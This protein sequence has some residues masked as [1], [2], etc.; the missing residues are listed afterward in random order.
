MKTFFFSPRT[1]PQIDRM[2]RQ[3][4]FAAAFSVL[5]LLT[6]MILV[7][8]FGALSFLRHH[9]VI[10]TLLGREWD[11]GRGQLQIGLFVVESAVVAGL[12]M[13]VAV[14]FGLGVAIFGTQVAVGF[15]RHGLRW[16]LTIASAVPSVAYG[17]WGLAVVVPGLRGLG[18]GSGYSLLAA[19]LV[20]ALMILPTFSVLAMEA[21]SQV[22]EDWHQASLALGA[23][24][25]Q[26]LVRLVLPASLPGLRL[27]FLTAL[28]RAVGETMAVQMVIGGTAARFHGL[29]GPG[30]T[31]TT[32]ILT[33][34]A[35]LPNGSSDHGVLDLMAMVLFVGVTAMTG[36]VGYGQGR[37]EK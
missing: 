18:G 13:L 2:W 10:S 21:L 6:L 33:D 14:P 12:A 22:P 31:L 15:E 7:L 30:A 34:M 23:N 3:I 5:A 17:W 20:L 32:Q 16:T 4:V 8:L 11:P 27:A 19:G 25:D 28:A 37:A 36:W 1:Y 35:I 26:N 29:F 24:D 9:G